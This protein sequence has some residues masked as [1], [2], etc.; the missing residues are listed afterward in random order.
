MMLD[1]QTIFVGILRAPIKIDE[2]NFSVRRNILEEDFKG[3]K[4]CIEMLT[5]NWKRGSKISTGE[6]SSM[7]M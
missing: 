7:K 4:R 1:R 6:R 5:L 2:S 3:E